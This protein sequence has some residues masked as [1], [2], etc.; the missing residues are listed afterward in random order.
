MPTTMETAIP[1]AKPPMMSFRSDSGT[2]RVLPSAAAQRASVGS[3][4]GFRLKRSIERIAPASSRSQPDTLTRSPWSRV[5]EPAPNLPKGC[6]SNVVHSSPRSP[7]AL[8]CGWR[9]WRG[10]SISSRRLSEVH[11]QHARMVCIFPNRAAVRRLIW[12]VFAEQRDEWQVARR[13]LPALAFASAIS[14]AWRHQ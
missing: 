10:R 3:G 14:T 6:P 11:A 5:C 2:I 12:A 13:C 4:G 9:P 7:A 1:A 8:N